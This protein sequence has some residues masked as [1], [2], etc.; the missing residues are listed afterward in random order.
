[1]NN[2][3]GQDRFSQLNV[4]PG[5]AAVIA[6]LVNDNR[7]PV[8]FDTEDPNSIAQIDHSKTSAISEAISER[9]DDA[10]RIYQL[11]PDMSLTRM[12][13]IASIMSPKDMVSSEI[14]YKLNIPNLPPHLTSL[15]VNLIKE[16][17]NANYEFD[18]EIPNIFDEI[19]FVSGADARAVIPENSIDELINGQTLISTESLKDILNDREDSL[20]ELGILS[21]VSDLKANAS[22]SCISTESIMTNGIKLRHQ[23]IAP[24]PTDGLQFSEENNDLFKY[25]HITDN[26]NVL[27]VPKINLSNESIMAKNLVLGNKVEPKDTSKIS[28]K[29]MERMLFKNPN[30]KFSPIK[31][32]KTEDQLHRKSATS[33]FVIKLPS[34]SVIP[35][36]EPGNKKEKIG[37]FVLIDD[38]GNPVTRA[39]VRREMD[40]L[41]HFSGDRM[42]NLSSFL[43]EKAS[44]NILGINDKN[45]NIDSAA[46]LYTD[47]VTTELVDRLKNGIYGRKLDI[48]G[49]TEIFRI[50]MA[51]TLSN[52]L[53]RL[54]YIPREFMSYITYKQSESGIGKSL[55]DDMSII[56]SLRAMNMFARIVNGVKNN[57]DSTNVNLTLD[58][59]DPDPRKTIETAM[60]EVLLTRQSNVPIGISAP[61][62]I[63]N[64]LTRAGLRFTFEGHPKI[65]NTKLE[66]ENAPLQ[67]TMPDDTWD[68]RLTKLMLNGCTVT[69]EMIDAGMSG[70][71]FART[72][73]NNNILLSKRVML[74][75]DE[76][77]PQI[78]ALAAK[79]INVDFEIK[80]EI[81]K[82][83]K[84]NKADLDKLFKEAFEEDDKKDLIN[85]SPE[86][87]PDDEA[88]MDTL[89]EII[90]DSF[91]IE[92]PRP[93]TTSIEEQS[94][95]YQKYSDFVN[96]VVDNAFI[97]DEYFDENTAGELTNAIKSVKSMVKSSLL[98]NY[99][100]NN[101]IL[102]EIAAMFATDEENKPITAESD[103][104]TEYTQNM[105][106]IATTLIKNIQDMK[107]ASEKDLKDVGL[108]EGSG[109]SSS[110]GSDEFEGDFGSDGNDFP[111]EGDLGLDTDTPEG[112]TNNPDE[113]PETTSTNTDEPKKDDDAIEIPK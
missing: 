62:Q 102:P 81:I 80:E 46:K 90:V 99:L 88:L 1:M 55:L 91:S 98:R 24:E 113:S 25:L 65:P 61:N 83:L 84:D 50:M 40:G 106:R 41:N 59:K 20:K 42:Q 45:L 38:F 36:I 11:F 49:N 9:I 10:E 67:H 26:F 43:I 110:S 2:L 92:L 12:I 87:N 58:P 103:S 105:I 47:I 96:S 44:K 76:V 79:I 7:Q 94:D 82:L 112:S 101:G 39:S 23:V 78:K 107:N 73:T 19:L 64:W 74:I 32:F 100:S 95:A 18:K 51:R 15:I 34:E 5:A 75:Q 86:E 77:L 22:I 27:K 63:I 37:F 57:I 30:S 16:K 93:D 28:R 111:A 3:Q 85:E 70:I 21:K 17:L 52:Q 31:A 14:A 104:I 109:S 69:P 8:R 60:H 13:V 97:P 71:E 29:A 33:G 6:K 68:D 48:G 53:T 89:F 108:V 66:F 72:I 56:A 35:V 4:A 54:L